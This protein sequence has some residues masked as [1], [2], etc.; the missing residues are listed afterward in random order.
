MDFLAKIISKCHFEP[1]GVESFKKSLKLK[2]GDFVRIETWKERN[3]LLHRKYFAFLNTVI[4][5]L[6]E[7]SK[8]DKLRNIDYLR[9]E[10]MLLIGEVDLHVSMDGTQHMTPKSLSF[11]SMDES[12]FERVYRESVTAALKYFLLDI[13]LSDFEAYII[14]FL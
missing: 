1:V 13:E 11:K 14:N 5:F 12:E 10:I 8:F 3:I 6:P 2:E 9:K 4:Y 7:D